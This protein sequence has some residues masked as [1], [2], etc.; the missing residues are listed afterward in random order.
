MPCILLPFTRYTPHH[1]RLLPALLGLTLLAGCHLLPGRTPPDSHSPANARQSSPVDNVRSEADRQQANA[2]QA[3]AENR[4]LDALDA[5]LARAPLLM[6]DAQLRGNSRHVWEVLC[7]MPNDDFAQ[8]LKREHSQLLDGWVSLAHIQRFGANDPEQQA[9]QLQ[10]WQRQWPLHPANRYLPE[11]MK[12]LKRLKEEQPRHIALLLPLSGKRAAAGQAVRD[13]F[14][15]AYYQDLAHGGVPVRID[16]IDTESSPDLLASFGQAVAGGAQ[17]VVGPLEREQVQVLANEPALAVPVLALNEVS[18]ATTPPTLYQFSLNPEEEARQAAITASGAG[19]RRALIISSTRERGERLAQ[20]FSSQW[21]A[22]GGTVLAQASYNPLT[23]D[24]D[25]VIRQALATAPLSS[26]DNSNGIDMV[27]LAG[28]ATEASQVM[29]VLAAHNADQLPV[30]GTSR[31]Y[32]PQSS[33]RG[34]DLDGVH[35]GLTPWQAGQGALTSTIQRS[36]PPAAGYD[37]LYALGADAQDLYLRLAMMQANAGLTLNGHT[38]LLRMNQQ[39]HI[40]RGLVWTVLQ[41]GQ[42]VPLPN[43]PAPGL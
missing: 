32:N 25:A 29:P 42:P 34:N 18:R 28:R 21:Q 22:Q 1:A 43:A 40:E 2:E 30:Y 5:W 38:G 13:G 7:R 36:S 20:R 31:L 8:L 10:D 15:A 19:L 23:N 26:P 27:F 33:L 24:Y 39:R 35:L 12:L 3:V 6:D 9:N 11:D 17:V 14:L 4:Y 16:V 41:G 37:M